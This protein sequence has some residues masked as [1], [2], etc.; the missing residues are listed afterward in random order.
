MRLLYWQSHWRGAYIRTELTGRVKNSSEGSNV[1]KWNGDG[2][3]GR[4]NAYQKLV[5]I[6]SYFSLE[7]LGRTQHLPATRA[8]FVLIVLKVG[9]L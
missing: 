3:Q 9:I 1:E 8:P 7:I 6:S 5:S 2:T 4:S